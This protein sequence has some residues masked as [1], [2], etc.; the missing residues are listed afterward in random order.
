MTRPPSRHSGFDRP[1]TAVQTST[2]VDVTAGSRFRSL[3]DV[4]P[5]QPGNHPSGL[6]THRHPS[7]GTKFAA[8]NWSVSRYQRSFEQTFWPRSHPCRTGK[9]CQRSPILCEYQR[10]WVE[11]APNRSISRKNCP[12]FA[13]RDPKTAPRPPME[14][15]RNAVNSATLL[16]PA[17]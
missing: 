8:P 10:D 3:I 2:P 1:T 7:Y 13:R 11:Y 15:Q 9:N 5:P 4:F 16:E 14:T 17:A 12:P 6:P